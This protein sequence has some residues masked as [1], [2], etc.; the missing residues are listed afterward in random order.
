[1]RKA[2]LPL[3]AVCLTLTGCADKS[4]ITINSTY[5]EFSSSKSISE[6]QSSSDFSSKQTSSSDNSSSAIPD[7]ADADLSYTLDVIRNNGCVVGTAF[8]GYIDSELPEIEIIKYL[9]SSE[10]IKNYSYLSNASLVCQ[11]GAEL[12]AL[13]PL[14]GYSITVYSSKLTEDGGI[15]TDKSKPLYQGETG[16]SIILRCNISEVYSNVLI[17][18]SNGVDTLEF[19]PEISLENGQMVD[20]DRC[21]DLSVYMVWD[22]LEKSGYESLLGNS[23]LSSLVSQGMALRYIGETVDLGN[24]LQGVLFALGTDLDGQFVG[25]RFYAFEPESETSYYLD[26]ITGEWKV[27]SEG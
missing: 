1:M 6:P 24:G 4:G 13:T 27:L 17:E 5:S 14:D 3:L 15:S 10:T 11:E 12:Y 9:E 7:P 19:Q 21:Y 26:G 23:E 25:E 22:D 2:I 16:K 18:V 8:I 20:K